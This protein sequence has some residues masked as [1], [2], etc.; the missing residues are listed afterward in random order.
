MKKTVFDL[1]AIVELLGHQKI[2][3]KCTEEPIA[4]VNMLR[5]DVPE[6]GKQP[7]YTRWFG[8]GSVYSI[9]PCTEEVCMAFLRNNMPA[10]VYAWD[11]ANL[12]REKTKQLAEGTIPAE[13]F[14][15]EDDDEDMCRTGSDEYNDDCAPEVDRY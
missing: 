14:S 11:V 13:P 15:E 7:A 9:S 2:A 12:L 4:G 10:P 5:V 8:G 3:G 6:I 1:F